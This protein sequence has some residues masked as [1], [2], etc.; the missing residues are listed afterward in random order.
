MIQ[1]A[2]FQGQR[3][4]QKGLIKSSTLLLIA[5]AVAFFPRILDTLGVPAMVN[6]VHFAVL[7]F[8]CGI[9][10]LKTRTRNREQIVSSQMLLTGLLLLLVVTVASGLF[11]Q[12]GV[13]NVVL[14]YL[15]LAEPF[16]F[17]IALVCVPMPRSSLAHFRKWTTGFMCFH[18]GL[19]LTQA[20]LLRVGILKPGELAVPADNIQGVF[21]ISGS[22]HVVGASVSMT[23]GLYYFLTTKSSPIWLRG[24]V[25]AAAI[26]QLLL[27]D[28]KQVML[29]T[30]VSWGILILVQLK[31]IKKTF[32]YLI[33]GALVMYAFL[34]CMQNVPLFRSFNTWVK[35]ELYG[36]NGAATL[37]KTASTRIILAHYD[38]FLNWF[39]GLGPGHTVGRLGGWML[40]GYWDLL[41][42]LDATINP[43]SQEVWDAVN[44]TWL[45][46]SSSMFSPFFGWAA[47]W[48]D[49][50]FLGLAAYLYLG[51]IVWRRF[52][53][54][55]LSKFFLLNVIVHGFIFTQLEEPGYML[56]IA[57]VIGLEWHI[58][59]QEQQSPYLFF[60]RAYLERSS[61]APPLSDPPPD[62][63]ESPR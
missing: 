8:A 36:P 4:K 42:P 52:C 50:G 11:N 54:N 49:L 56:F 30:L 45:G 18:I 44:A 31:D 60:P 22:G 51:Y 55:D 39:L 16:I 17:L 1:E 53:S 63:D 58:S 28:A 7:P 48:G 25:L 35:P 40:P 20:F 21:Y 12:A 57:V 32:Q 34:W 3:E 37:L 23:F 62:L 27:A 9:A 24:G 43:V 59:Q 6:F 2:P 5:F 10:I 47:I 46:K 29:V 19:A 38:S 13:I 33:S 15:L 14:Q 41:K 26:L 61:L